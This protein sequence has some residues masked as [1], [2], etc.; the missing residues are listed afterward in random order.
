MDTPHPSRALLVPG[1]DISRVIRGCWQLSTG[2]APC[3]VQGREEMIADLLAAIRAGID[4][5]DF[6]DIY[7]GVEEMVGEA[8][9]RLGTDACSCVRLHTKYVPDAALLASHTADNVRRIV[10]RSCKRLGR[11]MVDLVQFHWWNYAVPGYVD[12]MSALAQL[13]A[14]SRVRL[15]GV[16]H[17]HGPRM[18]GV[19]EE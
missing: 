19:V 1:Y 12:A 18:R 16:T 4:T 2:H 3:S 13:Q 11:E 10:E 15:V 14:E 5:L 6:G 17:F 8:L 9:N 7:L